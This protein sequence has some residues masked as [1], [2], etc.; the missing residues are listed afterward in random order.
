MT[1]EGELGWTLFTDEP[2]SPS[3]RSVFKSRS[4]PTTGQV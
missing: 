4:D 1:D 3:V 2:K